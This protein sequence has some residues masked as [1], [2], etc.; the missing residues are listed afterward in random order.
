M[1]RGVGVRAL[2]YAGVGLYALFLLTAQFEHHD[3]ICHVK[4]PQHCVACISSQLGSDP[5]SPAIV[6]SWHLSDAGCAVAFQPVAG[7]VLLSVRSTGRSPPIQ[8]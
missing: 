3:L 2:R 1:V 4:T 5:Y 7:G 8:L 6:G